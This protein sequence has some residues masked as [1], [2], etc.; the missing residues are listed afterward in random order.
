MKVH[1]FGGA[2]AVTGAN[3]L[4]EANGKKILVDCGMF[5]GSETLTLLNFEKFPYN[6]KD[7]DYLFI[8]HSHLDHCGRAP[9]LVKEG[10]RGEVF[11]TAPTRDIMKPAL[12]DSAHIS[13]QLAEEYGHEALYT[14]EDVYNFLNLIDAPEYNATIELTPHISFTLRNAG[15]ILGS[16]MV[17]LQIREKN[18]TKTLV[19]TGDLGNC[20]NPLLPS[21]Y[22]LKKADY[23]FIE[24]AYG[25]RNHETSK[26]KEEELRTA[27]K[28]VI[29]RKGVLLIPSFAIERTQVLLYQINDMI[30]NNEI[31]RVPV[32]LD[33]P[34]ATKIT[35]VYKK[36]QDQFN[37]KTKEVISSG[38][39]IFN[40]PLL[41]FTETKKESKR[42]NTSKKPKI[43]IAG[44]G[45][46]TGGRILYHEERYLGDPNNMILFV[47]YQVEGTLGRKIYNKEPVV[48]IRGHMVHN[49]IERR[50]I[51]G[52]SA[53]ADQRQLVNIIKKI[54]PKPKQVF[55]VQ[56]EFVAA[57]G[58]KK[59]L[60][61]KA[62]I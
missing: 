42:I 48:K 32:Y 46:S 3:Y 52:Y 39:D 40:F 22:N 21:T 23:V 58:L 18:N 30:E 26:D 61:K 60:K 25:D 41:K 15:H 31:P 14:E 8:T 12:V 20:P 51:G 59:A 34:L 17:E 19:F 5:Q 50:A 53:H 57:K 29:K 36:H 49:R 24:A 33:S 47:G 28:D 27:I 38:D 45:M 4:I 62:Q 54:L 6:P 35:R 43:I 44:A 13:A 11:C 7:I 2:K 9:K 37:I 16:A 1:F 55:I 56:G 10:F